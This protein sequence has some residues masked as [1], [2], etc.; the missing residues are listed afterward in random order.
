MV[1]N[2]NSMI[3]AQFPPSCPNDKTHRFDL[4][5]TNMQHAWCTWHFPDFSPQKTKQKVNKTSQ[6]KATG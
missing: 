1:G 3:C 5:P 6:K 2:G 4:M